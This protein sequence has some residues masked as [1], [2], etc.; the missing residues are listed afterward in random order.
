MAAGDISRTTGF[1]VSSGNQWLLIGTIEVDDTPRV[2]A[3]GG[4]GIRLTSCSLQ[5]TDGAGSAVC[6]INVNA[7]DTA[8]NGSIKANGN[9]ATVQ[10][11][12]FEAR[13]V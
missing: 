5:D 2:F 8:T 12:A 10:T 13:Y 4:T 6:A 11:Y 9:H 3:L 1:P 7:S